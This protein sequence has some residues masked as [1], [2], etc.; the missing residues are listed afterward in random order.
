MLTEVRLIPIMGIPLVQA[1]DNIADLIL[2]ACS[3]QGLILESDD[4]VVISSKIISK[5]EGRLVD[6]NMITP[7]GEAVALAAETNKDPRLV[8]LILQESQHISRKAPGILI[9]RHRLG[10]TSA[11]SAIDQSNIKGED[12][13]ALLLPLDPDQSARMIRQRIQ[14]VTGKTTGIIVSDTHGRPFR[15]GNVGVAIGL[16]GVPGIVDLRGQ[17]DLY[18]RT[19]RASI[20]GVADMVASAATLVTG[21]GGEGVP[22]VVVRGL[23]VESSE[24]Q[25]SD[26]VRPLENDLYH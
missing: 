8:E 5:A 25:A 17:P 12:T 21:E 13:H 20:Q 14:F 4:I 1:H 7:S 3:E 2:Q 9:T 15:I 10:F 23:R 11:N 18:G 6:L 16:G 26:L 19:F 22:V 24:G